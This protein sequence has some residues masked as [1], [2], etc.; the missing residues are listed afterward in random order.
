MST[1]AGDDDRVREIRGIPQCGIAQLDGRTFFWQSGLAGCPLAGCSQTPSRRSPYVRLVITDQR[2]DE[3]MSCKG[4]PRVKTS[5]MDWI[6]ACGLRFTRGHLAQLL[7]LPC[8]SSIQTGRFPHE[9]GTS[10]NAAGLNGTDPMLG[11]LIA[12]ACQTAY[13]STWFIGTIR[14]PRARHWVAL[15]PTECIG[16]SPPSRKA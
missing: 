3:A 6:A 14:A 13:F 1:C 11:R 7:C 9:I 12:D 2:T 16:S 5:A 4:N 8:R 10:I 15:Q